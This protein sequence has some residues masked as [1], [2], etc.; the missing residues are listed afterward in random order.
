MRTN[1]T[2]GKFW[3]SEE[4][5]RCLEPLSTDPTLGLEVKFH[6]VITFHLKLRIKTLQTQKV[7][8]SLFTPCTENVKQKP[9]NTFL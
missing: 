4:S 2:G 9:V 1:H 7:R 8:Q 5:N 3:G 6:V